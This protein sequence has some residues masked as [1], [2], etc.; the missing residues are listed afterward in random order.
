MR[1]IAIFACAALSAS[2]AAAQSV[3]D[4]I[5]AKIEGRA[6]ELRRAEE[7]LSN[8]DPNIRVAAM[9]AMIASGDPVFLR[10]AKE[11]GL[12]SDDPQLREAA[13]KATLDA[14]GAFRA[15]FAIPDDKEVT[16]IHDWLRTFRGSWSEDGSTGYFSFVVG[17]FSEEK[18]CWLWHDSPNCIF[19]LAGGEV[20]TV[21]WAF[22]ING[23]AVMRLD[24][25]GALTGAFLVNGRG[26]PVSIRIP[27]LD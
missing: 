24:D 8:P 18:S 23:A 15:E 25:S 3:L 20:A 1:L 16:A 13:I 14:G 6:D 26:K 2:A 17:D 22:N 27:L 7:L 11:V 19:R 21:D 10:K 9:E 5:E 12:F 4:G